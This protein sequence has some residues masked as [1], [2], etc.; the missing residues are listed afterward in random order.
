MSL[1]EYYVLVFLS[2]ADNHSLRMGELADYLG[3]IPSRLTYLVSGLVKRGWVEKV[4][5]G[6]D[7]RG[8]NVTLTED[9]VK[10]SEL[11][12]SLHQDVVS[13]LFLEDLTE[14]QVEKV[15]Q[16]FEQLGAKIRGI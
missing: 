1:A 12:T 2:E 13:S 9:G 10:A 11:G 15:G 14:D 4:P 8:L 7:R 3:Y 6:E 16:V 5:S